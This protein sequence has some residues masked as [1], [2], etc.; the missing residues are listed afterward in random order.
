MHSL[1]KNHVPEVDLKQ[2]LYTNTIFNT[3][4]HRVQTSPCLFPSKQ[5]T[6]DPEPEIK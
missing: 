3:L 5:A 1:Q 6:Y 4:K 2:L